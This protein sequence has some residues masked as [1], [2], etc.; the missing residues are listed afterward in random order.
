L[1]TDART[2]E[3]LG[4]VRCLCVSAVLAGVAG[5][6]YFTRDDNA[7]PAVRVKRDPTSG[8]RAMR[9]AELEKLLKERAADAPVE[10]DH[11]EVK[12]EVDW[13]E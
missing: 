8:G 6:H 2:A 1:F 5:A 12:S 3:E 9:R 11:K 4:V 10:Y 13:T 7:E